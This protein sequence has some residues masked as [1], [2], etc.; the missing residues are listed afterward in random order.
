[1][2]PQSKELVLQWAESPFHLGFRRVTEL[3]VE[4]TSHYIFKQ[5]MKV[6]VVF[7]PI[8]SVRIQNQVHLMAPQN[9][10]VRLA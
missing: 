4:K 1:M 2:A 3:E 5:L 6:L 9:S 8:K 10:L 7:P